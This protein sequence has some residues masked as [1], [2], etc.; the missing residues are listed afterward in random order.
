MIRLPAR[1]AVAALAVG[2][3]Q[4]PAPHTPVPTL[5]ADQLVERVLAV[6][7]VTGS[8]I[9]ATLTRSTPGSNVRDVRQL[10]IKGRRDRPRAMLLYQ[11]VWPRIPGGRALVIEDPGNHQMKGFLYQ[12]NHATPLTDRMLEDR[13]FDSDLLVEDLAE[14][15]WH[16]PSRTI[17]GEEAIGEHHCTIVDLRPAADTPTRYSL[18]KTWL[19][20]DLAIGL[21]ADFFGRDGRLAKRIGFYRIQKVHDRWVPAIVTVEPADGR[22]RTVIEGAKYEEIPLSALDFTVA[23]VRR[24][25]ALEK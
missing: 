13:F 16:W 9:H 15:F 22:S 3:F 5:T 10:L 2:A 12:S 11:Q 25:V 14:G 6:R 21:R 17:A 7:R 1:V 23:A 8:L 19:S 20:P 18:I 4:Q 24:A